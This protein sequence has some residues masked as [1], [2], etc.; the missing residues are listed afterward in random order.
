MTLSAYLFV[1]SLEAG[2]AE[3]LT[4]SSG[5]GVNPLRQ[6]KMTC[7]FQKKS[8]QANSNYSATFDRKK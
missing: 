2:V 6:H 7:W 3:G 1:I 4:K 8:A 5:D